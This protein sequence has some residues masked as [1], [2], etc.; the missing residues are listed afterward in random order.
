[1]IRRIA[2]LA[3]LLI[4]ARVLAEDKPRLDLHGDPLPPGAVARL[5]TVRWR[6]PDGLSHHLAFSQDGKTIASS[7]CERV[8]LWEISSG[9]QIKQLPGDSTDKDFWSFQADGPVAFSPRG[10]L[11]VLSNPDGDEIA[12]YEPELRKKVQQFEAW[13]ASALSADGKVAATLDRIGEGSTLWDTT[14]GKKLC[15]LP[16][17]L[18]RAL[19]A[20]GK[21]FA[22]DEPQ[23]MDEY[24]GRM[25]VGETAT[26]K[27]LRQ[28]SVGKNVF[29]EPGAI[30]A[31]GKIVAALKG[32]PN[33]LALDQIG[34][35]LYQCEIVLWD[36][37]GEKLRSLKK[38]LRRG[39]P[40]AFSSDGKML[41]IAAG[42]AIVL[43]DTATGR[44]VAKSADGHEA[45]IADVAF[46]KG[47]TQVISASGSVR[48][49]DAA[50][51]TPRRE[52]TLPNQ[53]VNSISFSRD[54]AALVWTDYEHV[55]LWDTATAKELK[56]FEMQE[57]AYARISPDG[58]VVMART[59]RSLFGIASPPDQL[60]LWETA[61]AK[62]IA[63]RTIPL[64]RYGNAFSS[65][66]RS[67]VLDSESGKLRLVDVKTGELRREFS[68]PQEPLSPNTA[69][70]SPDGKRLA[71]ID[72]D[73]TILVWDVETAKCLWPTKLDRMTGN[74]LAFSPDSKLL[75]SSGDDHAVCLRD[76]ATG[77]E[78]R[79][80]SGHQGEV[81][82]LAF[83]AD[84]KLLAS[85]SADTTVLIWDLAG[86]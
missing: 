30:S 43:L 36:L 25:F 66:N 81:T 82:A 84:G 29:L 31:D 54:G 19:S 22:A 52:F 32:I 69:T 70:M 14:T 4:A 41:A 67:I 8:R 63:E 34:I 74:A 24:T 86:K 9:R 46:F 33:R 15:E 42:N 72:R 12:L 71:A 58:K 48:T 83:S 64:L 1:M 21:L 79:R 57:A 23:V 20:D 68:A 56:R 40:R 51:G 11:L 18:V 45:G 80:L 49:W 39:L 59:S 38:N 73:N 16:G 62:K 13:S 85:G 17:K 26:G 3:L 60:V 44:E 35:V 28:I 47:S 5:G 75:A 50:T 7:G 27:E 37:D 2:A 55:H 76:A 10:T 6:H 78:V 61:S 77:K 65:D 53:H